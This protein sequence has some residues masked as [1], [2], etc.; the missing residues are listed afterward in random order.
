MKIDFEIIFVND[1]STDNSE[2]IIDR[3]KQKSPQHIKSIR[4]RRNFGKATALSAGFNMAKGKVII[5][6]DGDLQD[7]PKEIPHFIKK[8]ESGFD[9]VSGWKQHRRDS[10][11]KNTSSKLFNLVTRKATGINLHDFN[12]GFKA[13][14]AETVHRLALYG[15]LHRYIPALIAAQGY[16]VGEILVN[17]RKR[18]YGKSKYGALRFIYGFFDLL[19]VIF[20]TKYRLRPLHMIGPIG[21]IFFLSGLAGATY[22]TYEKLIL[23]QTIGNRP[24]LLLSVMSMIMG[25]QIGITG[26]VGEQITASIESLK[27][28]DHQ[29]PTQTH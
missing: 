8:I 5:T 27:K 4:L 7:D 19:T 26:L 9:L 6:M 15:E 24:L 29:Q 20:I 17:H 23:N 28:H 3:L 22:L 10:L 18:R 12:C 14:R 2:A 11:I 16:Q 25:V 1:G 21:L 13:Y